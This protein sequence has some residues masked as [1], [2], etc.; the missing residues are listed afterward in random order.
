MST[1]SGC[2][3]CDT[4][5][6]TQTIHQRDRESIYELRIRAARDHGWMVGFNPWGGDCDDFCEV[7]Q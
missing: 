5:G 3:T 7:H 4:T 6:C 2:I 1:G